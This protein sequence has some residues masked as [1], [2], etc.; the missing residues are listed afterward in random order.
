MLVSILLPTLVGQ[1][2]FQG[3][4][5]SQLE[6]AL[7]RRLAEIPP[8][9]SAVVEC[10]GR[11]RL[12]IVVQRQGAERSTHKVNLQAQEGALLRSRIVAIAVSEAFR[13][14][15]VK[16]APQVTDLPP[17]VDEPLAVQPSPIEMY[18]AAVGLPLTAQ[19]IA[20]TNVP[21]GLRLGMTPERRRPVP[22]N[23]IELS[24]TSRIGLNQLVGWPVENYLALG[25][26]EVRSTWLTGFSTAIWSRI[27]ES[28][29]GMQLGGLGAFVGDSFTGVQSSALIARASHRLTGLQ[30]A[31]ISIAE[32]LAGIQFGLVNIGGDVV[33]AQIGIVNYARHVYGLQ[34]GVVNV[35][36]TSTASVGAVSVIDGIP[37]RVAVQGNNATPVAVALKTGGQYLH[38]RLSAGWS[39]LTTLRL[40]I[41]LGLRFGEGLG[42]EF[43]AEVEMQSVWDLRRVQSFT[44]QG[45]LIG[46][47]SLG[48]R[49]LP[50]LM[51]FATVGVQV[52]FLPDGR[53]PENYSFLIYS[54]SS[55]ISLGP[56]IGIGV[57]F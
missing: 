11:D 52:L 47:M 28:G 43:S 42:W 6:V 9:G 8:Q 3:C 53:A 13:K 10:Q 19:W 26:L 38:L 50:R 31:P 57:E 34:L 36:R 48:Y 56:E 16:S 29:R 7:V 23:P 32:E 54:V 46:R 5:A 22:L 15:E 18:P 20:V 4:E 35:A 1:I 55:R 12:S 27:D 21:R 24:L 25:I 14:V 37:I 51:P 2:A 30:V 40:G 44:E 39:L 49:L 41:G 45:A 17:R 33:G